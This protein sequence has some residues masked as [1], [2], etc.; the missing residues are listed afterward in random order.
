M[1]DEARY[2]IDELARR[3]GVTRR[4]VRYYV[5]MGLIPAPLGLGR[6]CH[7]SGEHL[8]VL[9]QVKMLQERGTPL[10]QIRRILAGVPDP[11]PPS[12]KTPRISA[13]PRRRGAIVDE[14]LPRDGQP[15]YGFAPAAGQIWFR[16]PLG[17]GYELTVRGDVRPLSAGELARLSEALDQILQKGDVP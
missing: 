11:E 14:R 6:G 16:Q 3:A 5:Q 10:E 9:L 13:P 4:T 2:S 1:G 8:A 12:T 7:Y 15:V 17:P